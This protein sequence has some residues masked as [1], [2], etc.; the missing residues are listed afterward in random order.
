M[1]RTL[2]KIHVANMISDLIFRYLLFF[3]YTFSY[4]VMEIT[5]CSN[6]ARVLRLSYD[7]YIITLC[8]RNRTFKPI[9]DDLNLQNPSEFYF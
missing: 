2:N 3:I 6:A 4:F 7:R 1:S 9:L 5:L 8:C